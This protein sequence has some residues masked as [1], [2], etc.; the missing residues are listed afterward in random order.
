MLLLAGAIAL[1]IYIYTLRAKIRLTMEKLSEQLRTLRTKSTFMLTHPHTENTDAKF[2]M[3]LKDYLEEHLSDPD[4]KAEDMAA[5]VNMS[6]SAFRRRIHDLTGMTPSG[7][8]RAKRMEQAM[9]LLAHSDEGINQ[10]A[11]LTG[12]SDPKYFSRTFKKETGVTPSQYRAAKALPSND[13]V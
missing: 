4:M 1:A 9:F 2:M 5:A 7:F 12:F 13:S 6:E 10:V 11:Y 8:V 3:L